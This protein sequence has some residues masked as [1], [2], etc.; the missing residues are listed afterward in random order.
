MEL[1]TRDL[2]SLMQEVKDESR[3]PKKEIGQKMTGGTNNEEQIKKDDD[4][5][6]E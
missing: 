3:G 1:L 6:E 5:E 2:R 4:C